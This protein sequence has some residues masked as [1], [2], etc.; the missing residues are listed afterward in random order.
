MAR[1]GADGLV[2]R[3]GFRKLGY[4]VVPEVVEAQTSKGALDSSN[5][6][7]ASL[8]LCNDVSEVRAA[9]GASV[10]AEG[11]RIARV[12]LSPSQFTLEL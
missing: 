3:L 10:D 12:R 4:R 5:V 6:G 8:I 2:A 1:N 9:I 7:V 11:V